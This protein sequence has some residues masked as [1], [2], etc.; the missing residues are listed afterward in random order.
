VSVN[1]ALMVTAFAL[2]AVNLSLA[3]LCRD[4]GLLLGLWLFAGVMQFGTGVLRMQI[5]SLDRRPL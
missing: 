2:A 5:D 3:V 1:R 4:D